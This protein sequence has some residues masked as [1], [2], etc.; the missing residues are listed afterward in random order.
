M[1][2][3]GLWGC[4]GCFVGGEQLK[5]DECVCVCV[6]STRFNKNIKRNSIHRINSAR[7]SIAFLRPL[8][9]L[10]PSRHRHRSTLRRLLFLRI[11]QFNPNILH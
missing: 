7:A 3:G 4:G 5:G 11:P 9:L 1:G 2:V 10:L 8:L 6:L